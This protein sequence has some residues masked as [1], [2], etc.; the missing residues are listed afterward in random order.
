MDLS[1]KQSDIG[2]AIDKH[3]KGCS[4]DYDVLVSQ[5]NGH[6][7]QASHL[8][9]CL[10]AL[11]GC[12][13]SLDRQCETL[14]GVILH[15]PWLTY[16][17][18][19]IKEYQAF[20]VNLLSAHTMYLKAVLRMVVK[21][22]YGAQNPGE[23]ETVS[24][25]AKVED[26]IRFRNLHGLL[27]TVVQIV[28]MTPTV[29]VPMLADLFPYL[30]K[31]S[32]I[33]ACYVNNLL[34]IT[35]YLP[36]Y[37]SK[38]IEMI[39]SHM[40]KLDVRSPRT[41]IDEAEAS[42]DEDDREETFEMD[43][44]DMELCEKASQGSSH[45]DYHEQPMSH[46][47]AHRLDVL[48]D[49]MFNYIYMQAHPTGCLKWD[50]CAK[51][52]KELLSVF[53]RVLL[54][55]HAS[56]HVQF[57]L[58]YIC[59]FSEALAEG[60]IDYLWKKVKDPTMQGVFRQTAVSYIASFI[61]RSNYI[62]ASMFCPCLEL[63]CTWV[64]Q[65]MVAAAYTT[66]MPDL[67]YHAA[68]YSVCQAIFYIIAF[69]QKDMLLHTQSG[70]Q[71]AKNLNLQTI[72]TSSLNPLKFCLPIIANTFSSIVRQHQLCFCDT[73]LERNKRSMLPIEGC[74]N[75]IQPDQSNP[76]DSFFPFDPYRLSRSYKYV[77]PLFREYE[78]YTPD[79]DTKKVVEEDEMYGS[80][81]ES[82][83]SLEADSWG[84]LAT[85]PKSDFLMYGVSPGFK[86]QPA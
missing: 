9:Q 19:V 12:T 3:K 36:D 85:S 42:D 62:K 75:K 22:C 46:K 37:R 45:S 20:L 59:S 56:C 61:A 74:R 80:D 18:V 73:V 58:F 34:K 14:V 7:N 43:E 54:R 49:I 53:D 67:N 66:V 81:C 57:L 25:A 48:M 79:D 21:N 63:M 6:Q 17:A 30:G 28:P 52:Y 76:L 68:F 4:R 2:D 8:L 11:K 24:E 65:Y 13:L 10:K 27:S 40:T 78:G 51:L 69:R 55:T 1:R 38:I 64:H 47:E 60:F 23:E 82:V 72:V 26:E 84:Q 16:E 77:M 86:T 71:F 15:V 32:Y 39:I 41:A 31:H 70:F 83:T 44:V 33:Q 35:K 29:L 5:L 50:S